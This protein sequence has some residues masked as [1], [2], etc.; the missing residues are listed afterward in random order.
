LIS[1]VTGV[2]PFVSYIRALCHDGA[3]ISPGMRLWVLQGASHSSELGYAEELRRAA[4]ELP[5]V[6]Y[7]PTVSRPWGEPEWSGETGRVDELIRKYADRWQLTPD[8]TTAYLCGNPQMVE[9]S[10]GI[11]GRAGFAKQSIKEEVFWVPQKAAA[12]SASAR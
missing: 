3:Q 9:N 10:K 6:T 4:A 11:L 1:T 12:E 5:W 8:D 7:V 2:A